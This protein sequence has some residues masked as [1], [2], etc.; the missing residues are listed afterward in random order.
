MSLFQGGG[1]GIIGD[2]NVVA[3][4]VIDVSNAV[5]AGEVVDVGGDTNVV[6]GNTVLLGGITRAIY[7]ISGTA[8]T[9]DGN[10]AAAPTATERAQ[11]GMLFTADGNFYGDNRMAAQVPFLLGGTVQTDWGGNVGY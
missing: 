2:R 11:T 6:R 7:R 3:S 10:I 5:D 8:N 1:I 9:L 4:N